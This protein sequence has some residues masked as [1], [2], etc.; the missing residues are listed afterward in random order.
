MVGPDEYRAV[1]DRLPDGVLIVDGE[2]VIRDVNAQAEALFGYGREELMG[3]PVE[4]LLPPAL[5]AIHR[6]HRQRYVRRLHLRPMGAGLDL[7]ARHRDGTEFDVE[8]SLSP[9]SGAGGQRVICAVRDIT[10]IKRLRDF[11]EGAIRSVEEERRRIAQDLHDDTAQRL[12]AFMLRLRLLGMRLGPVVPGDVLTG[13]R[14][15]VEDIAEGVKRIARGLR[16]PELEEVGLSAAIRAHVRLLQD[17]C[18]V[19]VSTALADVDQRLSLDARLALY[20]M[21]QES[22]SNVVRHSGS[23]TAS[24]TLALDDDVVTLVV[25]DQGQGFG[26][27]RPAGGSVG[28]GLIGMQER[29]L[30]AG[31]EI[32]IDSRP[33]DGTRVVVRLPILPP[34]Q[35]LRN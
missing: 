31:G 9:W 21:V 30:M 16:P 18:G 12:A 5:A 15:E 28:L 13:L 11:S 25:E 4:R 29:A 35:P 32:E 6:E 8:I 10:A 27:E 24:V 23:S 33:G 19:E 7:R 34:R 22:L 20:R 1:F 26:R 17:S 3:Q 2:G 14:D